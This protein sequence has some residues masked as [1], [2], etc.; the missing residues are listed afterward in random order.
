MYVLPFSPFLFRSDS[1]KEDPSD[2]HVDMYIGTCMHAASPTCYDLPTKDHPH[3]SPRQGISRHG[4]VWR[5]RVRTELGRIE[6]RE[7]EDGKMA[8]QNGVSCRK[9]PA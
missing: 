9:G 8:C 5:S 6:A 2:T 3:H 7:L 4:S 1:P